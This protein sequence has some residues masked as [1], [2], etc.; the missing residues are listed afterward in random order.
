LAIRMTAETDIQPH[1]T[2]EERAAVV[3]LCARL[4]G[5][6]D[7][8]QDLAQET[9]FL[10]WSHERELRDPAKRRQ[11]VLGIAR[12]VSLSWNRKRRRGATT[13]APDALYGDRRT[14]DP[15]DLAAD[16]PEPMLELE[17]GELAEL[18]DRAMALLPPETRDVL[19]AKY[20]EESPH[21][22]IAGRLGL[23]EG[24]LK[25]R[26]HR[27]RI[28]LR[29]VLTTE[30]HPEAA[31]HGLP[32][33]GVERWEETRMWCVRCGR[34][35]LMGRFDKDSPDG[36]FHLYCPDCHPDPDFTFS[37][38]LIGHG[39]FRELLGNVRAYKP[40]LSRLMVWV[41]G[42]YRQGLENGT[43]ACVGCGRS[44]RLR[45]HLPDTVPPYARGLRGLHVRCDGCAGVVCFEE[46]SNLA[47]SLPEARWFWREHPRIRT[48]PEREV[49]A[50]GRPAVVTTFESVTDSARLEVVFSR[51]TLRLLGVHGATDAGA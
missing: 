33:E 28:A 4:T 41:H 39:H 43:V 10:A 48:L 29:R 50:D 19:V 32:V 35:R 31:A 8:A 27:G 5:D 30:L 24:A 17:R 12:N 23:S 26:L 46:L 6:P 7:A 3:R 51:E 1:P 37:N 44:A 47:L 18:L 49:K 21:S 25:A 22:E 9:L 45:L 40:A 34:R 38:T 20:I 42:Y 36:R 2:S 11:W 14:A 15:D 16:E 13:P